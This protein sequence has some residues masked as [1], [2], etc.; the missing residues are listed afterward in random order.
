MSLFIGTQ[1]GR[2]IWG[3]NVGIKGNITVIPTQTENSL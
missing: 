3:D 1:P 2:I